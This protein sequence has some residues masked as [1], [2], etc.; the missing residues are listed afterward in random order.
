ML[1]D[2]MIA[3]Q[4][5]ADERFMK[6][7][8]AMVLG[9]GLGALADRETGTAMAYDEIAG[10]PKPTV[11]GHSGRIVFDRFG[12]TVVMLFQGRFHF[13]E[14]YGMDVVTLFPR[15]AA[16]LGAGLYLVTNAAG[17]INPD[18]KPGDLMVIRDHLNLM[19]TNPLIGAN[20]DDLGPRFP[21]MTFAYN[22]ELG[23]QL[24]ACGDALG[25]QMVSGVYAALTGPSYETPAEIRMLRTLGADA[26]GMSTVPEVIVASHA[27]LRSAGISCITNLAAGV[28]DQPLNHEE[29]LETGRRVQY[30]FANIVT[31][32]LEEYRP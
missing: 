12:D 22:R 6:P 10:F 21:D 5:Q 9:S 29:V 8:V 24:M 16:R 19:G 2:K 1:N 3:E 23:D 18:F 27:G 11:A 28:T 15:L 4:I 20:R 26:I 7:D 13:Y 14:G 17:G 30:D 32:F 31:R 25:V